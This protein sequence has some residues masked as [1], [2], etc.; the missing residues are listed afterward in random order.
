MAQA[1]QLV[2]VLKKWPRLE[3][4]RLPRTGL[5]NQSLLEVTGASFLRGLTALDLS[6]SFVFD[7]CVDKSHQ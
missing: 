1:V 3:S 4:L 5:Y 6:S 2:G 7:W